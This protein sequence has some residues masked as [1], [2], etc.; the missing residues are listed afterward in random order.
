MR[1]GWGI[2]ATALVVCGCAAEPPPPIEWR[3]VAEE[4]RYLQSL[5]TPTPEQFRRREAIAADAA[6][7]EASVEA[8]RRMNASKPDDGVK[9]PP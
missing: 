5:A 2:V 3:N 7:A 9:P 8:F 6:K 1:K 4:H